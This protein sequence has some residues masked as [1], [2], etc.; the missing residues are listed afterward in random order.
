MPL[1]TAFV[2]TSTLTKKTL[3]LALKALKKQRQ[4]LSFDALGWERYGIG[5]PTSAKKRAEI[6]KAIAELE[7]YLADIP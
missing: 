1:Q 2:P 6:V 5:M 7:S 3:R 4:V